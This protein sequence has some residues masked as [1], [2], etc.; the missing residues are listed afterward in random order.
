MGPNVAQGKEDGGKKRSALFYRKMSANK[1][2]R[3]D[4]N[5]ESL[6]RKHNVIIGWYK[7]VKATGVKG[8]WRSKIFVWCQGPLLTLDFLLIVKRKVCL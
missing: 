2:R 6:S 7:N 4:K 1:R 3:T 8:Y 5:N